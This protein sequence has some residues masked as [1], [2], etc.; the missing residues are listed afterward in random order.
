MK[1]TSKAA[2]QLEQQARD[3]KHP[4]LPKSGGN[5]IKISAAFL[6]DLVERVEKLEAEVCQQQKTTGNQ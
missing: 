1:A 2:R 6:A 3:F 4:L 5:V